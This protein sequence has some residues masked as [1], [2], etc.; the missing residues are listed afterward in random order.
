MIDRMTTVLKSFPTS[1]STVNINPTQ[2]LPGSLSSYLP[3]YALNQKESPG[4]LYF[5]ADD[6][7]IYGASA[8]LGDLPIVQTNFTTKPFN[9]GHNFYSA[10]WCIPSLSARDMGKV[11][12]IT[13]VDNSIYQYITQLYTLIGSATTVNLTNWNFEEKGSVRLYQILQGNNMTN[14]NNTVYIGGTSSANNS[15][16]GVSDLKLVISPLITNDFVYNGTGIA[17]YQMPYN[18]FY[19]FEKPAVISAI[20]SNNLGNGRI[21]FTLSNGSTVSNVSN[22]F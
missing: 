18:T 4:H 2:W 12:D 22:N 3:L 16:A 1:K 17:T 20:D 11:Y 21:Y 6:P 5:R 19:A 13:S 15:I 7:N 9:K 8:S 10:P 14:L